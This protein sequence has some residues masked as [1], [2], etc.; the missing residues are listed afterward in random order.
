MPHYEVKISDSPDQSALVLQQGGLVAFPTETVY[1]LGADAQNEL[2]IKRI[3][4]VKARPI[5]H[6]IIVHVSNTS[7]LSYWTKDIPKFAFKIAETFWPGPLTL[8]LRKSKNVSN[9]ITGF[10]DTV[11]IRIPSDPIATKFLNAFEKL[12]GHGV[13]APSA[14]RFGKVSPTSTSAVVSELG[15]YLSASDLI[16]RGDYCSVGIES[17]IIDCTKSIPRILRPGQI[18]AEMVE[19]T[20]RIKVLSFNP[21]SSNIGLKFSG[22]FNSH[23]APKAEVFIEGAPN[24]GDGFIAYADLPTPKGVIRLASPKNNYE[25]ARILYYA[26]RLADTRGLKKVVAIPAL[27]SGIAEAI[28]D[29][30]RRASNSTSPII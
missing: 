18:S 4:L 19:S 3:Y 12:G 29:R 8:I 1:G 16:L 22:S 30:L 21:N 14:N 25:Y 7:M 11:G 2:A 5:N 27:G 15:K 28:N 24:P 20:L 26:L 6:P 10:Q 9:F 23:Y 17:T 13:A